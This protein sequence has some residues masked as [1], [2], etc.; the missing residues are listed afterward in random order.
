MATTSPEYQD[1]MVGSADALADLFAL[2]RART[3]ALSA[4]LSDADAT[5]QSM[6]DASPAKW[7]LAHTTWFLETFILRDFV[8]AYAPFDE[9]YHFLFNSYYEGEGERH[10][11]AR[12]GMVTR[13]S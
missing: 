10:S 1:A 5:V 6:P 12:R 7:H 9:S 3:L 4:T 11:R 2:T 13:P 8:H